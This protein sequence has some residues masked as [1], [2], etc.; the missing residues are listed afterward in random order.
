MTIYQKPSISLV[1]AGP[2]ASDLIT[3]RGLRVI[4]SA[5]VILYDSLVNPDLLQE[6]PEYALLIPVGKRAGKP[7][8]PQE[9]INQLMVDMART[10]GQVVRLKGGDPFVFGR[11]FEEVL[12]AR[13]HGIE[14][15]VI[16]GLSSALS[17][18]A[19]AGISLTHRAVSRGFS[20][21]TATM[22]QD[23]LSDQIEQALKSQLTI[24]VLMGVRKLPFLVELFRQQGRMDL[25]F[26]AIQNGSLPNAKVIHGS[27]HNALHLAHEAGLGSPGILLFG[28][29]VGQSIQNSSP[30]ESKAKY[31]V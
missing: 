10:Y 25:P 12:F 8:M 31:Y 1:G 28:D 7:S 5:R 4:Q 17:V 18:P 29:M 6:A 9:E 22:T 3:V 30:K 13:E 23:E 20:V 27:V 2:G 21:L 14:P 24:V 15:E 26:A 11:G 19:L 16:P